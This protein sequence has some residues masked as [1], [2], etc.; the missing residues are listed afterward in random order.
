MSEWANI[1]Y[2]G[3]SVGTLYFDGERFGFVPVVQT[4]QAAAGLDT[5]STLIRSALILT[6]ISAED[7]YFGILTVLD[8]TEGFSYESASGDEIEKPTADLSGVDQ[9][10]N[11][12][13]DSVYGASLND[14]GDVIY[15]IQ[16][17]PD[18]PL[19]RQDG[20]W[21][22]PGPELE[23][24]GPNGSDFVD[25]TEES[26]AEYDRI[27]SNN[28]APTLDDLEVVAPLDDQPVPL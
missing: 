1:S 19:I 4:A 22:A 11:D 20:E 24:Y 21:V 3:D 28:E 23:I 9:A 5:V 15:V 14:D 25:I 8:R 10:F 26:V 12:Q 2:N 16:Q 17:T 27:V 18:G 7:S 6:E 13:Y